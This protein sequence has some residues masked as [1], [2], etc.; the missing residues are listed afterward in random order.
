MSQLYSFKL[1]GLT[2]GSATIATVTVS[3][4]ADN[5][6]RFTDANG[7]AREISIVDSSQGDFAALMKA[8]F[9]GSG[10][11]DAS[12]TGVQGTA[13]FGEPKLIA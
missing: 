1:R 13:V 8:C 6:L 2:S 12:T 7:V 9:T 10:G 5:Y 4:D 3:W 11:L